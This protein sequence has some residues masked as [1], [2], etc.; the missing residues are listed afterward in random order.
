MISYDYICELVQ[1]FLA[2]LGVAQA[3]HGLPWHIFV[4]IVIAE[5]IK[6]LNVPEC[7]EGEARQ[8]MIVVTKDTLLEAIGIARVIEE[9]TEVGIL[10]VDAH[11]DGVLAIAHNLHQSTHLLI[12]IPDPTALRLIVA[13]VLANVLTDKSALRD[14]MGAS[15]T[16]PLAMSLSAISTATEDL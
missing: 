7:E 15:H 14:A 9:S 4:A 1:Q 3:R 8:A 13:Y 2:T 6:W 10:G 11:V 16:P 12:V 5:F